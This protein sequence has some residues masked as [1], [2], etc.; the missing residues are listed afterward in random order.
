MVMFQLAGRTVR[1]RVAGFAASFAALALAA[2]LVT[3]CGGLLETGLRSDV[4]PQ[5]LLTAPI[6]VTGAQSFGGQPLAERGRL[7]LTLAAKLAAVP[8]VGHAVGDVSFPVRVLRG[9]QPA[10]F[11]PV[12]AHGWSSAQLT[13]YRLIAGRK[14]SG[15]GEVVLSQQIAGRLDINAGSRLAVLARGMTLALRVTG[16]AASKPDQA[17]TLFFTDA[18]AQALLGRPGQVDTIAVYPGRGTAATVAAQRITAVLPAGSALVLTGAARG[19]AEFPAAAGQSTNLVPL[20]AVS[21]GLMTMVAVFIVASTLALSVQLR[22]R[23]IALLRAVGATPGQVRRL[24]LSETVLLALPAVGLAV[25]LTQAIGRRLLAAFADHGLVAGRLVYHQGYVPTLSGAAIAVLTGV[26]A[27]LVAA[28]SAIRVRPVEALATDDAPQQWLTGARLAFGVLMLAGALALALV[29][30]LVFDGPVAA[31]TAA[32][33]AILWATGLAL[34]AP[35]ATRPVLSLL[36]RL[37]AALAPRTGHLTMLTVRGRAARTA[38]LVTPVMLVTGL[39]TSLLYMQT[40]QQAAAEHAY[41]RHLRAGLVITSPAGGIPLGAAARARHLPGV[42][43]ASPLVTSTGFFNVPPGANPGTVDSIPLQG[44]DGAS[45]G[46]VADYPVTAGS[47]SQL[48][49]DTIAIPSAYRTPGRGLGDT[50]TLRFGD[51]ATRRLRIVAVFASPRGYPTLLL[52]ADLLAAHTSTGLASQILVTAAAHANRAALANIMRDLAP[53]VHITGR[54][55]TLAAFSAQ[56]QTGAW[57]SYLFIAAV[58]AYTTVSLINT[59][60]AATARRRPQLAMLRRIGA[61]R[62]QVT[63]AMTIE[64]ILVSATGIVLGT[65]VALATLLPF[66]SALGFPG[67]PAGPP[68]IYLTVTASAA[69]LT[70]LTTRLSTQLLDTRPG[71]TQP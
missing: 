65:L 62:S 42:A 39:A 16:I 3:V 37:A 6:L 52:P 45:A 51:N 26:I 47:L 27:A 1:H 50:V 2:L 46:R 23:Q 68:S 48:T 66:D 21:G 64:A 44:L 30:A 56:Q 20:A 28:R 29:T 67:L 10:A 24:V 9:G 4:P 40:A 71:R 63:R 69:L 54:S 17:P 32:P 57:V 7:P 55:A 15:P 58:I 12:E 25:L 61:G 18:R 13:P 38:A 5:R 11:P 31:S 22:R 14:S 53:G 49:G 36:G 41:A 19:R 59:T 60:V 43:A 8:G 70:L 33:S 34:L 35:A